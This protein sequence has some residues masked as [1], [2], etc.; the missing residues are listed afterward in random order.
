MIS[1]LS[2]TLLGWVLAFGGPM[3]G[4]ALML[5]DMGLPI[6]GTL[7]V[8]AAGAYSR[9]GALSPWIVLWAF[10]GAVLGD[11]LVYLAGRYGL[12]WFTHRHVGNPLWRQAEMAFNKRGAWAIYLTRFLVTVLATPAI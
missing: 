2:D 6:P 1:S 7:L 11:V 10:A 3:L 4:L 12:S 9:S 8:L 5:N